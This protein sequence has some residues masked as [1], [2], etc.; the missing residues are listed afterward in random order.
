MREGECRRV[1][2]EARGGGALDP[3][4][5]PGGSADFQQ[6]LLA[7][8]QDPQ[9]RGFAQRLV[10]DLGLVDDL[11]QTVCLRLTSL[12]HPARVEN[13]RGYYLRVMRNEAT[14]LYAL[15][16]ET[17]FEDPDSVRDMAQSIDDQ[18]CD[19]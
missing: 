10:G 12:K 17:P 6:E 19:S 15:R 11:H 5:A 18:V 8:R 4:N 9:V 1:N 3:I 2:Q 14:K 13:I 7:I 16:N